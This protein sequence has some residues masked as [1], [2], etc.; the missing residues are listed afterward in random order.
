[1]DGVHIPVFSWTAVHTVLGDNN[2]ADDPN[3]IGAAAIIAVIDAILADDP[4]TTG[5]VALTL[6]AELSSAAEE[7]K[8][9]G[10]VALI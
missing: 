3:I 2:T 5:S 4:K 6:P 8:T 9:T 1:V 7:P 10:S